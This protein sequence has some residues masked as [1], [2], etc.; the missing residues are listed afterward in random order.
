[1][2]GTGVFTSLGYQLLDVKS[3]FSILILWVLGG[4]LALCG[5]FSYAELGTTFKESG[6]DYIFLSRIFH[7][8]LGYL[9]SW[10]ALVVGFSAPV[11]LAAMAMVQ[12]LQPFNI[13]FAKYISVV[14]IVLV[15]VF[16]S[17]SIKQSSRFH[18]LSTIIK[19]FFVAVL[20]AIGLLFLPQVDSALDYSPGWTPD[21][22]STG[23]AVSLIY[24]GFAYTGWNSAAFIVEEINDVNR[25]LPKALISAT[26][27]VTIAY[28]L[29]QFVMLKH[30]SYDQLSAQVEVTTIAFQNILGS[31]VR[32][33]SLFIAIQLI[34]TISG[35]IWIGPRITHSMSKEFSLWAG[36]RKTNV[37]GV[38]QRAIWLHVAISILFVATGTFEQVLLYAG[39]V[40]QL[41]TTLA[42]L[43]CIYNPYRG[44]DGVY[45]SPLFPIPQWTF[46]VFSIWILSFTLY[47][48][49]KE[50]LI[51][52]SIVGVGLLT[53][54]LDDIMTRKK[55]SPKTQ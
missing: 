44:N 5:A 48:R 55:R 7:P 54:W 50:S 6:G 8:V 46:V 31:N 36:L 18:N 11:A 23:F 42:I 9:T 53:Y 49:P 22:I 37:Q 19:L 20:I 52:L 41:M 4:V 38:P 3:T 28:V 32:F 27:I 51:G 43:A 17:V 13:P 40:L 21:L 25:N 1:M 45:K 26:L 30:A 33:V 35:Y 34:A 47:S 10:S 39:F 2:I 16:H 24:V 15:G 14:I 12:Y 29:M